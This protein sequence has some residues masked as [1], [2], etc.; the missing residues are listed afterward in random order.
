MNL[1]AA[2]VWFKGQSFFGRVELRKGRAASEE[3]L[4]ILYHRLGPASSP[5]DMFL[6]SKAM[7]QSHVRFFTLAGDPVKWQPSSLTETMQRLFSPLT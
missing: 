5:V 7:R 1:Q 6:R 2:K 3:Q 4:I